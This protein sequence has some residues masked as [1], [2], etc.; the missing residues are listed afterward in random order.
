MN[1]LNIGLMIIGACLTCIVF[2]QYGRQNYIRG[3]N[4]A[5][6]D[7]SKQ[8]YIADEEAW[9]NLLYKVEVNQV[10]R[11]ANDILKKAN[12]GSKNGKN[13]N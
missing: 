5:V 12:K 8:C 10:M 4:D 7:L 2:Q 11:E 3:G 9:E 1:K 6:N 13:A